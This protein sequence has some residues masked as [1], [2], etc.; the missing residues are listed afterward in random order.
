MPHDP[1]EAP[2][3]KRPKNVKTK[4]LSASL[5]S[6]IRVNADGKLIST[7]RCP[8]E[9]SKRNKAKLKQLYRELKSFQYFDFV[10]VVEEGHYQLKSLK[11]I[12]VAELHVLVSLD[13]F[14]HMIQ[15]E[16]V[17]E[18]T[19]LTEGGK[20]QLAGLARLLLQTNANGVMEPNEVEHPHLEISATN[21]GVTVQTLRAVEEGEII[22]IRSKTGQARVKKPKILKKKIT[23]VQEDI[24]VREPEPMEN[25]V[26]LVSFYRTLLDHSDNILDF[27]ALGDR[28]VSDPDNGN[29]DF[30]MSSK[31]S[32]TPGAKISLQLSGSACRN[33]GRFDYTTTDRKLYVCF[34]GFVEWIGPPCPMPPEGSDLVS[35][36]ASHEEVFMDASREER[37]QV[38]W[39]CDALTGSHDLEDPEMPRR[40]PWAEY[41]SDEARHSLYR[42]ESN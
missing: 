19:F 33:N 4:S 22:G 28:S 39:M 8:A 18:F 9:L 10:K 12:S 15:G 24:I 23:T 5:Y 29:N 11:S 40:H 35:A 6:A 26:T 2:P 25:K 1:H 14:Q 3:P 31:M 38:G 27:Q 13:L 17:K 41:V 21:T 37:E 20:Y 30:L 42:L 7:A 34:A 16:T 36:D 32:Q